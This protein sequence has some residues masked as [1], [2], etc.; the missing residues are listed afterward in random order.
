MTEIRELLMKAQA[1][2]K[3]AREQLVQ[4]NIGLVKSIV[5]RY[6]ARGVEKED[7]IQIGMI[8]LIKAIDNFDTTYEVR[9]STYAVPMIAGEIRR[10]LRDNGAIKV[11]RSIKD[12]RVA[13][14]RSRERLIEKLGRE[15]TIHE[16]AEDVGLSME[17]ILLA[18]N[19]GQEV[20]SLQQM[21][22][23]GDGSS[24]RLMDR[25]SAH[26]GEGDASLD[27]MMLAD[28]LSALEQRERELIVL[29]FYYDQTQ[30]QIAKRMG[31]SQV[32]VSRLEKRILRKMKMYIS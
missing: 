28:S 24:I 3:E 13:V 19:S 2:D 1:G 4:K 31:V 29:R 7:L 14:N 10:F 17:D 22:Y 23:E 30:S 11:S 6:I 12:H 9:F 26:S 18:V 16:I 32:Q 25:L 27:R 21:I 20:A 5:S 15:P 8:G